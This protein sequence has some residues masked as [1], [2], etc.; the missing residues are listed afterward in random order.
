[1]KFNVFNICY[2]EIPTIKYVFDRKHKTVNVA[3]EGQ[4]EM[5]IG[6]RM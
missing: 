4:I 6:Y 1:M 5:R 2:M 3:D